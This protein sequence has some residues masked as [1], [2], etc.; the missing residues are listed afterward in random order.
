MKKATTNKKETTVNLTIAKKENTVTPINELLNNYF[1]KYGK[2]LCNNTNKKE[3][4]EL[5]LNTIGKDFPQIAIGGYDR[6]SDIPTIFCKHHSNNIN[7][8]Q[9]EKYRATNGNVKIVKEGKS[10]KVEVNQLKE[11]K[12]LTN[13]LQKLEEGQVN[14]NLSTISS[15]ERH[16]V[17]LA[18][19]ISITYNLAFSVSKDKEIRDI[20]EN[21]GRGEV[22]KYASKMTI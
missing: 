2:I 6:A 16:V 4:K 8:V 15:E 18:K 10:W 22:Y 14:F 5:M 3:R 13:D 9:Q 17:A 11:N 19:L 1:E 7:S 12:D 21:I 20:K